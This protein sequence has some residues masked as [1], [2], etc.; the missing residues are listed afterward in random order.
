MKKLNNG[1]MVP[2]DDT[3]VST[4]LEKDSSMNQISYEDKYRS[5]II[6]SLPN[7]RT[8]VD[9]GANVGIWSLPMKSHFKN[10]IS[11]EPSKQNI[12][13]IKAN[14]PNGIEL[15]EKAVA[16]FNG[17]AKFHQAGKNCGDGK[18]CREGVKSTY[19]VPVVKLD[20]ENLQNVDMVKIDTQGWELDVL[21]GMSNL[22][23]SQQ[24]WI[25]IEVNED[26]DKCC[27]LMESLNYETVYVKSKRNFVWAPKTGH[28]S[29]TDKSIFKRYLGPGPYAKRYG[30]KQIKK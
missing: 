16:D 18:L 13:C 7:K 21:K 22:I 24:P 2:E 11:Y 28:N 9:V 3:R 8:F 17:E 15:R 5:L 23:N 4:L 26:I 25:M 10:V 6:E 14:I 30:E 27:A 1:W 19:V 12:E 29:P 20:D